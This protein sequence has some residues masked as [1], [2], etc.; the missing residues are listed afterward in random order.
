MQNGK[1]NK[2]PN[3]RQFEGVALCM[4]RLSV[5]VWSYFHF[6]SYSNSFQVHGKP[7]E[8]MITKDNLG[9]VPHFSS[10]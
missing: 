4:K 1:T 9:M 2:E 3:I 7:Y 8:T 10:L 6:L 5:P